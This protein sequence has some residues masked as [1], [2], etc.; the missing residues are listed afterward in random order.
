ME[1]VG[2]GSFESWLKQL[3]DSGGVDGDVFGEYISG[4]LGTMEESPVDEIS[5][6]LQD[7]LSGCLV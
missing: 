1:S 2:E 6:N 3:L 7:I 5:E 4:T